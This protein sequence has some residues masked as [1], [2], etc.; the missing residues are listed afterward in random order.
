MRARR[1]LIP[2]R[3][4][5]RHKARRADPIGPRDPSLFGGVLF[6]GLLGLVLAAT[7]PVSGADTAPHHV[8]RTRGELV[9]YADSLL[10]PRFLRSTDGDHVLVIS[11]SQFGRADAAMASNFEA[12]YR[13]LQTIL[14]TPP[15]P[16]APDATKVRAY[17][18]QD[19]K[20]YKDF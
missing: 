19:A 5:P 3:A 4:L 1:I 9:Q 16:A 20:Q 13:V 10:H 15:D 12:V 7:Q 6:G 8:P 2:I 18:F 11:D 17:L 14:H